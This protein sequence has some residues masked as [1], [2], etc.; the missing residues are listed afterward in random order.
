MVKKKKSTSRAAFAF[1]ACLTTKPTYVKFMARLQRTGRW[2]PAAQGGLKLVLLIQQFSMPQGKPFSKVRV[3][4]AVC[5]M[6]QGGRVGAPAV[7][8]FH[9]TSRPLWQ[10]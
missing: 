4:K 10:A 8:K 9:R 3:S 7:K 1:L 5:Y 6:A 2:V